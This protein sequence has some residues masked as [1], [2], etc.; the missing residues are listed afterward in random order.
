[1]DKK[2]S[3]CAR[4]SRPSDT[5]GPQRTLRAFK[6]VSLNAGETK[7]VEIA[8]P[9]DAFDWFDVKTERMKP[10]VGEYVVYVGGSSDNTPLE[11]KISLE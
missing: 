9:R 11:T 8:M 3:V 5:E 2:E 6:R 1:M 7:T 10:L 4:S